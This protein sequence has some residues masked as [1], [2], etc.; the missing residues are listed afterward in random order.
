ML[1]PQNLVLS[2][3]QVDVWQP[4]AR[5][6]TWSGLRHA[7]SESEIWIRHVPAR[8]TVSLSECEDEARLSWTVLRDGPEAAHSR[9]LQSPAG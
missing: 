6:G 5:R 4:L 1:R 9:P 7:P 8:R 3:P 2:L